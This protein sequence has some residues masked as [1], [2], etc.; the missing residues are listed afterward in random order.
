MDDAASHLRLFRQACAK[1]K[2]MNKPPSSGEGHRRVPSYSGGEHRRI[3]SGGKL[4]QKPLSDLETLFFD[5]ELT[6][7]E[8]Q[9]CRDHICLDSEKEKCKW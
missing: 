2:Q 1:M 7:E 4:D 8:N 5:L 6:M 9:L 3:P